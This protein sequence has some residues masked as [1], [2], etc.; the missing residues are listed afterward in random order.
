MDPGP[1]LDTRTGWRDDTEGWAAYERHL[2]ETGKDKTKWGS[3]GLIG[4]SRGWAIGTDAWRKALAAEYAENALSAGLDRKEARDLREAAWQVSFGSAMKK[5]GK[6]SSDL[7]TKPLKTAW[8]IEIA[9]RVRHESGAS[10][11]WLA[12]QLK[13]GQPSS[14]RCYLS[15]SR[16]AIPK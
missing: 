3:E 4:L 16:A 5:A 14:L 13:I 8:K 10:L 15:N 6:S 11:I 12:H 7:E 9:E 1:W 2:V